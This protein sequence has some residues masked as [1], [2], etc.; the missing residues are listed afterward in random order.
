MKDSWIQLALAAPGWAAGCVLRIDVRQPARGHGRLSRGLSSP[1]PLWP[2]LPFSLHSVVC[3]SD[4]QWR[5]GR[6]PRQSG[7]LDG[8]AA[9]GHRRLQ[10]NPD[11]SLTTPSGFSHRHRAAAELP[12]QPRA[13]VQFA[14]PAPALRASGCGGLPVRGLPTRVWLLSTNQSSVG[15]RTAA[16]ITVAPRS[17]SHPPPTQ[18]RLPAAVGRNGRAAERPS[19]CDRSADCRRARCLGRRLCGYLPRI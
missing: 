17:R 4:F 3:R 5:T 16:C 11:H 2:P 8:C 10:P 1:L 14:Q 12:G 19:Q 6:V 7:A 15:L 9:P 18:V 13:G